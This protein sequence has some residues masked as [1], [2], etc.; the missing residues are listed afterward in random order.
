[1]PRQQNAVLAAQPDQPQITVTKETLDQTPSRLLAF[2]SGV[3]MSDPI[4]LLLYARGYTEEEH[5]RGWA[6]L[7]AASGFVD[8]AKA[9]PATGGVMSTSV[10]DAIDTLDM[11]DEDGFGLL[12]STLT[13]RFPEQASFVLTG[14]GPSKGAAAVVGVKQVLDRLDALESSPDRKA[15]RKADHAALAT[16]AARGIDRA[17]R[18]RLRALITVA[19]GAAEDPEGAARMSAQ[20]TREEQHMKA[21]VQARAFYEEWSGVARV[22]V[23]RRDQLMRL[24]LAKRRV[25]KSDKPAT[26][27]PTPPVA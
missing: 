9:P 13:H 21:L 22:V 8:N 11:W 24:G 16:L 5:H 18:E 17:E 2:L 1:M 7:H 15:T 3:G 10:R 25:K 4:K 26:P 19:E 6:L 20:R 12:R 23:K 14:L 27:A